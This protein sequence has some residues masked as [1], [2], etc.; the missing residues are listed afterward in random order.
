[1]CRKLIDSY[2]KKRLFLAYKKQVREI[3]IINLKDAKS[4]GILWNPSDDESIETYE[5]LRKSLNEKGIKS[6]GMAYISNK[7]GKETLSTVANSWILDNRDVSFCGRPKS[8][9]G[10]HFVQEEFDILVD[11]SMAKTVPLQYILVHSAA[12]FKVGWQAGDTNMYDLEI[13][14]NSNPSCRFLMEQIV[15]YLEKL[16]ENN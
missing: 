9:D 1:M 10:V 12:K 11:L 2:L 4:M 15:Y 13:D 14:V 16:N 8:G 7:R 6:F 3:R 5:S